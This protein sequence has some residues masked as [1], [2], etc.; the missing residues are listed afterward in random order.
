L[1]ISV[2]DGL[3]AAFSFAS[4]ASRRAVRFS[5]WAVDR[6]APDRFDVAGGLICL[7]GWP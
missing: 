4:R 3:P 2:S 7:A 6:I 5:G 1:R